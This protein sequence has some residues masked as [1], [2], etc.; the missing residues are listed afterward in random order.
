M[1]THH[2]SNQ[3]YGKA[4]VWHDPDIKWILVPILLVV[5]ILNGSGQDP[6]FSQ[7]YSAPLQLNPGLAGVAYKPNFA[8]NYRNQWPS[9][10]NAYQTYALSYDQ[11]FEDYNS[12]IGIYLQADNAGDGILKTNKAA[13]IYSYRLRIDREWQIRWGI[14]LGIVQSRLNWQKLV[15]SDQL[16]PEFG[17]VSPGGTPVPTDE[18]YPDDLSLTYL[19]MGTGGVIYSRKLYA[20]LSIRHLN[21]PRQSYL[22][23]S[24]N[25]TSGLPLRW[26]VHIG[27]ELPLTSGNKGRWK[28]FIS[29]GMMYVRQ[30]PFQQLILGTFVGMGDIYGGFWYRHAGSDPDAVIGAV[31]LRKGSLRITY[32]YDVTISALSYKSGGSHEL[33]IMINLDDG[34]GESQYNDCLSLFR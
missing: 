2:R 29:P 31:G 9:L 16:D 22:S 25:L 18:V 17:P 33:G 5:S 19:D 26:N 14:E 24:E 4:F 10:N 20:G 1:E 23:G 13:A 15:F 12:G 11:Y 7:F 3:D 32:S 6:V 28:T 27:A 30:G 21:T 8:I 34:Q